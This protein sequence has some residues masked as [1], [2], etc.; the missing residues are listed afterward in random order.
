MKKITL[1]RFD[2]GISNDP[3]TRRSNMARVVSNFNVLNDPH[4]AIPY[5]GSEDGNTNQSSNQIQNYALALRTGTTYS[6][7]GLGVVTGTT[8]AQILY[9]NLTTGSVNDL[10]DADWTATANNASASGATNFNLFVYYPRTGFIYG[11]KAGT[12]LWAYDP[13]G[14]TTFNEDATGSGLT[15]TN[16]AQGMVHSKDDILYIP[17]DNKIAKNNNGSWNLSALTLPEGMV[18]KSITEYGNYMAICATPLSGVGK[19]QVFLWDRDSSLSTLSENISWGDEDL[20]IL[21]EIEGELIGISL[22]GNDTVHQRENIIFRRY[23][24][25]VGAIK[26]LEIGF[27]SSSST[28]LPIAKQKVNGRLFFMMK[29]KVNGSQREGVWSIGRAYGTREWALVHERTLQGDTSVASSILKNFILIGDFLFQSFQAGATHTMTKTKA[30]GLYG[31]TAIIE[32][33]INPGMEVVESPLKKKLISLAVVTQPLPTNGAV[34]LKV[35]VDGGSYVTAI[36]RNSD[37][38]GQEIIFETGVF[39]DGTNFTDGR[40]IEFRIESTNGAVPT[41]LVYKYK[42]LETLIT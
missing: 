9:K 24:A 39:A 37:N 40:E 26:F 31:T 12:A 11:A 15:Y 36:S 10:D 29:G 5:F 42:V 4:R 3:R 34:V 21:E 2:G 20:K 28:F 38:T 13:D 17:Y 35:K 23:V 16:I 18:I 8:R 27:E 33:L 30:N 41:G 32:T 19:S 1:N 25:G 22:A 14:G 7:Y 6:L